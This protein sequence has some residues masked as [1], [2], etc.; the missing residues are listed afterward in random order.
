M[1]YLCKQISK[2]IG[3][4]FRSRFYL[5]SKINLTLYYSLIYPY[6]TYCNSTWS[7]TYISNLNKIYYLQK[8]AVR[9][10]TNSDHRAHS[11]PLFS[12]LG[13]LVIYQLN[14]FQIAKFM[15]YYHNNLLPLLFFNLFLQRV[16]FI[17]IAPEQPIIIACIIAGL[18]QKYL[19]FFTRSKDL[20]SLPVTNFKK[21]EKTARVLSKIIT[22]LAKPH[23]LSVFMQQ[24]CSIRGGLN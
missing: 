8:R 10:I 24:Y 17:T 13:I 23:T 15:Y 9:A 1:S 14:T 21:K 12:K 6:I 11:A 3:M 2:T 16:K 22:E 19:Q 4:F 18:I 5:S 7:S 20:E